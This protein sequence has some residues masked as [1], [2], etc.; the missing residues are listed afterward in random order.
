MILKYRQTDRWKNRQTDGQTDRQ[1]DRQTGNFKYTNKLRN[2]ETYRHFDNKQ[3]NL[4]LNIS[5]KE[6]KKISH[7]H[8]HDPDITDEL[9]Q[10]RTLTLFLNT[11]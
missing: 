4:I 1:M 7:E 11:N 9:V 6:T 3:T 5:R 2:G 8:E 10:K